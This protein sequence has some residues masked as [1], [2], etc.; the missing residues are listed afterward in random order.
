MQIKHVNKSVHF[1]P[2]VIELRLESVIDLE[3]FLARY[4]KASFD[5]SA[6]QDFK[7]Q[8]LRL[9]WKTSVFG[10]L[11]TILNKFKGE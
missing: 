1:E 11:E 2:I 5:I 10:E 3:D 8:P 7:A 6:D 4:N 9:T